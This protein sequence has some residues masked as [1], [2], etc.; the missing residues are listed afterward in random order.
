[1]LF[2]YNGAYNQLAARKF[3]PYPGVIRTNEHF[4]GMKEKWRVVCSVHKDLAYTQ[5]APLALKYEGDLSTFLGEFG[6]A[7]CGDVYNTFEYH[8]IDVAGSDSKGVEY[9]ATR[10]SVDS[11]PRA[12]LHVSPFTFVAVQDGFDIPELKP[13]FIS[14]V[15]KALMMELPRKYN[16]PDYTFAFMNVY[17]Q[18]LIDI[19][20]AS[21]SREEFF[22]SVRMFVGVVSHDSLNF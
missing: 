10:E 3:Q 11:R 14:L 5:K 15:V 1:M 4:N 22:N 18:E 8:S 13:Y 12:T 9:R 21:E 20:K 6:E 17:S 16:K 7:W 2:I 19:S